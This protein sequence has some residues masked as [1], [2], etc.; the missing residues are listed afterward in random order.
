[1]TLG[2]LAIEAW[3]TRAPDLTKAELIEALECAESFLGTF[4]LYEPTG[5][6]TKEYEDGHTAYCGI[7]QALEKAKGDK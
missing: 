1:M 4:Y 2:K 6:E 3:N 7:K 5:D